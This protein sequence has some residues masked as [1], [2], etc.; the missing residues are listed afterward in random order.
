MSCRGSPIAALVAALGVVSSDDASHGTR[1]LHTTKSDAYHDG[2]TVSSTP[3]STA[4]TSCCSRISR[5]R[6]RPKA[7]NCRRN[8]STR[9]FPHVVID[10]ALPDA[11]LREFAKEFPE[12]SLSEGQ[13]KHGFGRCYLPGEHKKCSGR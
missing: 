10:N 12:V 9:P 11:Y 6:S 5:A 8:S 1:W 2:K 7:A 4:S 13:A 3:R